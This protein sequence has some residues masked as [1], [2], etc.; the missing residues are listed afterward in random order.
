VRNRDL[1]L[2]IAVLASPAAW[3]I[4]LEANY[5]LASLT[6]LWQWKAVALFVSAATFAVAVGSGLISWGQW[7]R[8]AGDGPADSRARGMAVGGA[9]LG[10][11]FAV[12][13]IA[14]AI[15]NFMLAGCQ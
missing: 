6:C 10:S 13:I 14:Q 15:P 3:F 7:R 5:A 4:N 8:L 11:M 9:V 2:W 12:V 1:I